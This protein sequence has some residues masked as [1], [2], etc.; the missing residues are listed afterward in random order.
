MVSVRSRVQTDARTIHEVVW[1]GR[2][3]STRTWISDPDMDRPLT[4]EQ[5]ME[6]MDSLG[7][8]RKVKGEV[9]RG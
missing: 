3:Y 9:G 8:A 1:D 4:R 6:Y 5:A 2:G 7:K